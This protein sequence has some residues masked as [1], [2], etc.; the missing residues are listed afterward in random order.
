MAVPVHPGPVAMTRRRTPLAEVRCGFAPQTTQGVRDSLAAFGASRQPR[1]ELLPLVTP[2]RPPEQGALLPGRPE[3]SAES[4][5][6]S[7]PPGSGMSFETWR[8]P[9][10]SAALPHMSWLFAAHAGNDL[11]TAESPRP[12]AASSGLPIL[13]A[14]EPEP[15]LNEADALLVLTT[16]ERG[17][18][19]SAMGHAGMPGHSGNRASPASRHGAPDPP[20]KASSAAAGRLSALP[21]CSGD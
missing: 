13:A 15:V 17:A 10:T 21:D 20:V 14:A 5:P 9:P 2:L 11:R 6:S 19:S 3:P 1:P 4:T 12:E 8:P 18:A 7:R 16:L